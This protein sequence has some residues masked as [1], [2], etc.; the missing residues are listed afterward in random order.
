M[1][2]LSLWIIRVALIVQ[3]LAVVAVPGLFAAKE[4]SRASW[5][6][7]WLRPDLADR[8]IGVLVL[9]DGTLRFMEQVGQTDWQLDLANVK[10][11]ALVN[12]G[13]AISIVSTTGQEYI[14]S[15]VGADLA[16]MSPK[17]AVSMLDR[18]IQELATTR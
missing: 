4:A 18:A 8:A 7:E 12:Q 16:Q 9:R 5:M 2:T 3:F 13:K 6:A 10:R 17:K 14:V 1:R 15:I 11:V